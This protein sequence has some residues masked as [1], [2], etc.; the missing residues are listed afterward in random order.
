MFSVQAC[1]SLSPADLDLREFLCS[2]EWFRHG[3]ILLQRAIRESSNGKSIAGILAESNN[4]ETVN[5]VCDDY[6]R[7][8]PRDEIKTY[9]PFPLKR[10]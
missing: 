1:L 3:I 6:L 9:A 5:Y 7:K 2:R 10:F 8:L 4:Q